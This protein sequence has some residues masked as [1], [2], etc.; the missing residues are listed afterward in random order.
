MNLV[1]KIANIN[2]TMNTKE[3]SIPLEDINEGHILDNI[4]GLGSTYRAFL[5][6][7]EIPYSPH[8]IKTHLKVFIFSMKQDRM[9]MEK[10]RMIIE[11][12]R[13]I[14]QQRRRLRQQNEEIETLENQRIQMSLRKVL[15]RRN[16][17]SIASANIN[18]SEALKWQEYL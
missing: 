9:L 16:S 4:D 1:H 3:T 2:L 15:S 13:I 14:A 5:E 7:V 17:T 10:E 18:V 12:E 11:K 6:E 8:Q